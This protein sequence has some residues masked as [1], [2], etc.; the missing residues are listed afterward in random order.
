[1][2]ITKL[3]S[4]QVIK[5][6]FNE[7]LSALST[8]PVSGTLVTNQYDAV[9]VAYTSGTVETYSFFSGGLAGTLVNTV[10]VTY[11]DNT[12]ANISSV[13]KT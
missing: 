10:V 2:A 6:A 9:S 4:P 12:K 11:T 8:H 7:S 5:A 13:V 3:D 1:M